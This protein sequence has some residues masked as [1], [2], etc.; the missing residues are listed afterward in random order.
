M[1]FLGL[2]GLAIIVD[3][4]KS[5]HG[6]QNDTVSVTEHGKQKDTVSVTE[7]GKQKDT[8]SV[9][10]HGDTDG[11]TKHDEQNGIVD[12]TDDSVSLLSERCKSSEQ[13]DTDE[14][15]NLL[16]ESR[17]EVQDLEKL[18]T[19]AYGFLV[20][21][22]NNLSSEALHIL[23]TEVVKVT[24]LYEMC[25]FALVILNKGK[26]IDI[27]ND[28][29]VPSQNTLNHFFVSHLVNIKPKIFIFQ[30]IVENIH[31]QQHHLNIPPN[32]IVLTINPQNISQVSVLTEYVQAQCRDKSLVNMF[33]DI[34]QQITDGGHH[35]ECTS[36]LDS[37][38]VL[39]TPQNE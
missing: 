18:F 21:R 12:F 24:E 11:A 28:M 37:Q 32:S 1:L 25:A 27:N 3:N 7:H 13:N 2:N 14:P 10:E 23:L 36:N 8:V 19:N 9:T 26:N 31:F 38:F 34:R 4:H 6:E 17:Q 39:V 22:F 16:G 33:D 5:R 29:I 15:N 20:L 30:T 35:I